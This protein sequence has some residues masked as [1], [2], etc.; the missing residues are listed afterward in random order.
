M[1]KIEG[2]IYPCPPVFSLG[3]QALASRKPPGTA[4]RFNVRILS[5]LALFAA[6]TVL[7]ISPRGETAAS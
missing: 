4:P 3:F 2:K 6:P 7:P 1:S 5:L